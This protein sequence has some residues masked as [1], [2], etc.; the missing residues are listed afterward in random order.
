MYSPLFIVL[1]RCAPR[2]ICVFYVN[3]TSYLLTWLGLGHRRLEDRRNVKWTIYIQLFGFLWAGCTPST[4]GPS[5]H[6]M[7]LPHS[8]LFHVPISTFFPCAAKLGAGWVGCAGGGSGGNV[9][10]DSLWLLA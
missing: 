6:Q 5:S 7:A 1:L 9:V 8:N 4:E 2:L 10:N 3:E